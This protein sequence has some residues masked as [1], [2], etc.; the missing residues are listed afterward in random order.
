[1]L[2]ANDTIWASVP[3]GV[4]K[5]TTSGTLL[6]FYPAS[7][8]RNP[9]AF[10][11]SGNMYV[12][13]GPGTSHCTSLSEITLPGNVSSVLVTPSQFDSLVNFAAYTIEYLYA[14]TVDRNSSYM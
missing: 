7:G 14:F 12:S 11:A 9:P 10:D 3:D 5:Y 8:V 6:A 1:M 4:L 2:D 13:L